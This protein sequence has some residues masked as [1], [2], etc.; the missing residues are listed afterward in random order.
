MCKACLTHAYQDGEKFLNL[1]GVLD[2]LLLAGGLKIKKQLITLGNT[3]PISS[4]WTVQ[5]AARNNRCFN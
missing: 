5:R 3:N 2:I 4:F 1:F